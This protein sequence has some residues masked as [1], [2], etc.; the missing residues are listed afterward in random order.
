MQIIAQSQTPTKVSYIHLAYLA[1]GLSNRISTGDLDSAPAF[2]GIA[3]T[4][5]V[6]CG[7]IRAKLAGKGARKRAIKIGAVLGFIAGLAAVWIIEGVCGGF[8]SNEAVV[9]HVVKT[10]QWW[11]LRDPQIAAGM[12][13]AA[14]TNAT[15]AIMA[16]YYY[17]MKGKTPELRVKRFKYIEAALANGYQGHVF[18]TNCLACA[19]DAQTFKAALVT[20]KLSPAEQVWAKQKLVEF[21]REAPR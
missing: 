11:A 10:W 14:S 17:E 4:T 13:A 6:V 12:E 15:A 9:K 21:G 1:A 20:G 5:A 8:R 19:W 3:L 7:T 18:S 16:A 2:L